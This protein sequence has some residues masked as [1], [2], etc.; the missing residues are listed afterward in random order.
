MLSKILMIFITLFWGVSAF[1][2]GKMGKNMPN[3][4][5]MKPGKVMQEQKDSSKSM[6]NKMNGHSEK[7]IAVKNAMTENSK[8]IRLSSGM[9]MLLDEKKMIL[10]EITVAMGHVRKVLATSK[11]L[12]SKSPDYGSLGKVGMLIE[13]VDK[14]AFERK[15]NNEIKEKSQ[16]LL[17]T[18]SKLYTLNEKIAK[19]KKLD[20][21][22][23]Q[24]KKLEEEKIKLLA[25][26][27]K[28]DI[29][30]KIENAKSTGD[31]EFFTLTE[32]MTL[33]RIAAEKDVYNDASKWN[34]ILKAN[35][36]KIKDPEEV[37]GKGTVLKIP[38]IKASIN[39]DS[40]N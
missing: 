8:I 13:K 28:K 18:M 1:S 10:D 2:S 21:M 19:Q 26:S 9:M 17:K 35:S 16:S 27:T 22:L 33:K 20:D 32:P 12:E 36:S 5:K 4:K 39:Y 6:K 24:I 30:K 31:F 29:S 7:V 3:K 40:M 14:T 25:N 15:I 11:K 38:R 23:N 37:L 34:Y